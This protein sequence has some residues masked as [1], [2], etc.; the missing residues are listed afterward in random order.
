MEVEAEAGGGHGRP[1][2]LAARDQA[3]SL[4]I[5]GTD[6]TRVEAPVPARLTQPRGA[7]LAVLP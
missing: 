5:R 2:R 7:K 1:M 3:V 6:A 4:V